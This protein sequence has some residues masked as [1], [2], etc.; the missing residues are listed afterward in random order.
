MSSTEK[1]IAPH[2]LEE[3]LRQEIGQLLAQRDIRELAH[4]AYDDN[5][6]G[7]LRMGLHMWL[8]DPPLGWDFGFANTPLG[9][10][11]T[12]FPALE[13]WQAQLCESSQDFEGTLE[14]AR[15]SIGFALF[16]GGLLKDQPFRE[17]DLFELHTSGALVNLAIAADRIRD[18]FVTAMF[19][20]TFK[21][22]KEGN[23]GRRLYPT[24]FDEARDTIPPQTGRMREALDTL[25][26]LARQVEAMRRVRNT[27][28]HEIATKAGSFERRRITE[29]RP[30]AQPNKSFRESH[31]NAFADHR[32]RVT[33]NL[34]TASKW[35]LLLVEVANHV[36]L[37][38]HEGRSA[39]QP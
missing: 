27:S 23:V 22:Y 20:V 9:R 3:Y 39:Q 21:K 16:H 15:L 10:P 28:I 17:E 36:F 24:P 19:R 6:A 1:F 18:V 32:A 29:L 30:D 31:A 38:E 35:Y 25:P 5:R 7:A 33:G 2:K 14:M 37:A 26:T 8:E 12:E 4:Y 11:L 13:P 34:E